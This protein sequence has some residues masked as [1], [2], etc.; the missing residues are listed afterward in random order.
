MSDS[1]AAAAAELK[2][3]FRCE[4]E[5][6]ITSMQ[7]NGR[8]SLSCNYCERLTKRIQRLPCTQKEKIKEFN[9]EERKTF[10]QEAKDMFDETLSKTIIEHVVTSSIRKSTSLYSEHGDLEEYDDLKKRY[11]EK[12]EAWKNIEKNAVVVIHPVSKEKMLWMPKINMSNTELQENFEHRKRSVETETIAKP[13]KAPRVNRKNG[14]DKDKENGE[15]GDKPEEQ[16][17]AIPEVALAKLEV[18]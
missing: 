14:G 16:M 15:N 10:Y 8:S 1:A 17:V 3:C 11:K 13:K 6:P 12:P 5:Y 18:I 2:Q 9:K 7:P 4:L